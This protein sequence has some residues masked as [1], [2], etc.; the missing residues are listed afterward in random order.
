M[1]F[2]PVTDLDALV[3]RYI[4]IALPVAKV[5]DGANVIS[6]RRHVADFDIPL[7]LVHGDVD[8]RVMIEQSQSFAK[9]LTKAGKG[10]RYIEQ[11]NG[12]HH[13][14]LRESHRREFFHA[15]DDFLN[16]HIGRGPYLL[17]GDYPNTN[18][19]RFS[20][21][22]VHRISSTKEN[23]CISVSGSINVVN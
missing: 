6:T 19:F 20:V 21:F 3:W 1:A 12:N 16:Q 14:S 22:C 15:M 2:A 18:R 17:Y 4:I 11:P 5:Q 23:R 13:L 10:F 7:L 8:R 9:V